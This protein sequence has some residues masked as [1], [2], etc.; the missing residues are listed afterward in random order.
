MLM[1]TLTTWCWMSMVR[2]HSGDKHQGHCRNGKF[3]FNR[4]SWDRDSHRIYSYIIS[5]SN[6]VWYQVD[7]FLLLKFLLVL[8]TN[9]SDSD[10]EV[11]N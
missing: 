5:T 1:F 9:E 8:V 7:F 10:R 3:V 2:E 11:I 6:A 4:P